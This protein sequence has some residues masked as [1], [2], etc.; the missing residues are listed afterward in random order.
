MQDTSQ[1][2]KSNQGEIV[3]LFT[4]FYYYY[5]LLD[6]ALHLYIAMSTID[7]VVVVVAAVVF[8]IIMHFFRVI[9]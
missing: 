3:T 9:H 7:N 1:A 5:F 2:A 4:V 8:V 6:V